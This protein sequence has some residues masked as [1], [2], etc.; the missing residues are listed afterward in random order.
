VDVQPTKLE[1]VVN[2]KTAKALGLEV[3]TNPPT[4]RRGDR[5]KRRAFI[6]WTRRASARSTRNSAIPATLGLADEVIE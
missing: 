6:T 5:M 1:L 2:L 3:P 4:R